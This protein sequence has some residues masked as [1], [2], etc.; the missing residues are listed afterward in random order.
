M[1][2]AALLF[3]IAIIFYVGVAASSTGGTF[4]AM[5][6]KDGVMLAADSRYS[7]LHLRGVL[8]DQRSR[9]I[10]RL[11]SSTL[12]GCFGPDIYA[13]VLVSDIQHVFGSHCQE[14]LSPEN[15]ARIVSNILYERK[16]PVC[17]IMIGLNSLGQPFVCSM[18]GIGAQTVS[19]DYAVVG[20][21]NAEVLA[22]CESL[23]HQGL[24][25]NELMD[26]GTKCLKLAFRRNI[27]SGGNIKVVVLHRDFTLTTKQFMF[28]D[29]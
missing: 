19:N 16:Y 26:L 5:A 4:L 25:T 22:L 23:Y 21:A 12:F 3:G 24:D 6:G 10:F 18:D 11:G 27:L 8:L 1:L 9:D 7:F 15:L 29:V 17:P 13:S 20:T 14:E 2:M 28:D